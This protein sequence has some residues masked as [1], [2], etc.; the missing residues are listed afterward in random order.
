M[1]D[2]T[3][4]ACVLPLIDKGLNS[5]SM[6]S[7]S[8]M[9]D[10]LIVGGGPAGLSL[11]VNLARS[12]H[13]VVVFDSGQYRNGLLPHLHGVVGWDH[14]DSGSIRQ[15]MRG[16]L[17]R[18]STASLV[19]TTVRFVAKEGEDP[20]TY[21]V[22]DDEGRVWLG[23]KLALATGVSDILPDIPGYEECWVRGMYVCLHIKSQPVK[24]PTR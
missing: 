4:L 15:K 23:R 21:R 17:A 5:I 10:I 24:K 19:E 6:A 2:Y 7:I 3:V 22:T 9:N 13:S 16:D 12:L 8:E 11:A 20:A 1:H 18:Y 14:Q